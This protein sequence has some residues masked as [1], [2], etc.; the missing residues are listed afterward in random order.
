[1]FLDLS[2]VSMPLKVRKRGRP[3]GADKTV[4]GLPKR[5]RPTNKPVPFLRRTPQERE[6]GLS[7]SFSTL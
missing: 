6:K 2:Q 7:I 4:I 3:K 5:K 1:M